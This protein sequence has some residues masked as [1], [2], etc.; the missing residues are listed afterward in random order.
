V[1]VLQYNLH[2]LPTGIV[3]P[4]IIVRRS[5][6][7][8]GR[9]KDSRP[10]VRIHPFDARKYR[11]D[12]LDQRIDVCLKIITLHKLLRNSRADH[13][14]LTLLDS[15]LASHSSLRALQVLKCIITRSLRSINAPM[16]AGDGHFPLKMLAGSITSCFLTAV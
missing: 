13:I 7:V 15:P 12:I 8:L 10:K 3:W 2:L 1:R 9:V 14:F 6:K 4:I 11:Y 5:N 16:K